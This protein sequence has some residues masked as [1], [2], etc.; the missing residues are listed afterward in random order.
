MSFERACATHVLVPA[1]CVWF[2]KPFNQGCALQRICTKPAIKFA[3]MRPHTDPQARRCSA[4]E[5][6]DD[7]ISAALACPGSVMASILPCQDVSCKCVQAA[8][9]PQAAEGG[10]CLKLAAPQRMQLAIRCVAAGSCSLLLSKFALSKLTLCRTTLAQPRQWT[11]P[12]A[13]P[14]RPLA[15]RAPG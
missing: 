14:P 11:R 6:S 5:P 4:K 12:I 15:G 3:D 9:A 1:A 13:P 8:R 2:V 7:A 10:P